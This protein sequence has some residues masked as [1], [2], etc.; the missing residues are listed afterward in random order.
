MVQRRK[1]FAK[2]MSQDSRRDKKLNHSP[3]SVSYP[4]TLLFSVIKLL[5]SKIKYLNEDKE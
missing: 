2:V 3:H 5:N 1:T 4:E